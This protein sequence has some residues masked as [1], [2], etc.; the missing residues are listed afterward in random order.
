[1]PL[2]L[3]F[4]FVFQ[5]TLPQSKLVWSSAGSVARIAEDGKEIHL[6]V[7]ARHPKTGVWA[8]TKASK[9]PIVA[10]EGIIWEHLQFS[11]TGLDLA[12][13]DNFGSV[14]MFTWQGKLNHMP[15]TTHI[16]GPP[17]N[18]RPELDA[19]VGLH[20]LAVYPAEFRVSDDASTMQ[21]RLTEVD[22]LHHPGHQK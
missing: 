4:D 13:A 15:P 20:W 22:T 16:T 8:L 18:A 14:H 7:L 1:M 21:N 2:F 10:P 12:A 5:L 6:H 17:I 9:Q 3:T 19:A 11:G